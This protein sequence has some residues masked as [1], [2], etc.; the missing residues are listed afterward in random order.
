V[1]KQRSRIPKE[2][3]EQCTAKRAT[4]ASAIDISGAD[5]R[6]PPQEKAKKKGPPLEQPQPW[7]SAAQKCPKQLAINA[8]PAREQQ[9]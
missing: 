9:R 7:T 4:A 5:P 8:E 3:H 2:S 6:L 1:E